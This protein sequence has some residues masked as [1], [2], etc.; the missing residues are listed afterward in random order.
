MAG[1]SPP[2]SASVPAGEEDAASKD[3]LGYLCDRAAAVAALAAPSSSSR[4]RWTLSAG[5][6][7]QRSARAP[8]QRGA[9]GPTARPRLTPWNRTSL[10]ALHPA[11]MSSIVFI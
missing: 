11:P 10:S 5:R 3:F 6:C 8:L 9:M 2:G 7:G 4:G 1:R